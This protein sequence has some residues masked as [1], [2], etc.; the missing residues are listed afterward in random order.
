MILT[1]KA[2]P[3]DHP[4]WLFEIKHDGFRALAYV[5]AGVARLVSRRGNT[6]RSF[7]Q[8]C[9]RI[10]RELMAVEN[11]IL[12]GELVCVDA[13]GR[14]DFGN[15]LHRRYCPHFFA[16]DLLWLNGKDLRGWPLINRKN[17]LRQLIPPQPARLFFVDYLETKGTDL[18]SVV[19]AAGREG[20]VAKRKNGRYSDLEGNRWIKIKNPTYARAEGR[21][22]MFEAFRHAGLKPRKG[23]VHQSTV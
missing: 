21:A 6:F 14:E 10:P 1:S 11:A 17:Q 23:P 5:E 12:D 9:Q 2:K 19:C 16:F 3:F 22:E 7:Q 15:L 13:D 18:Y 20:I 8:L 4:D